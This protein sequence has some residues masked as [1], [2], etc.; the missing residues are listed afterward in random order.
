[1]IGGRNLTPDRPA[2]LVVDVNARSAAT[3]RADPGFF[4]QFVTVPPSGERGQGYSTVTVKAAA[5]GADP[6]PVDVAIE[7]F[8]ARPAGELVFGF[9]PGWHEREYTPQTGAL[10]RWTSNRAA[11]DIHSRP[12]DLRVLLQGV[13]EGFSKPSHVVLRV[14]DTV[15]SAQDVGKS[16]SIAAVLPARLLESG[17]AVVIVETD[18]TSMPAERRFSRSRDRRPLGLKVF[19]CR[20]I[21]VS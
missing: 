4:L 21:P 14:G 10:W 16:F 3:I 1:M 12:R 15:L 20:I 8:D 5:A 11:I 9:G 19:D 13:T 7:Q 17:Q 6:S 18:Q 2:T